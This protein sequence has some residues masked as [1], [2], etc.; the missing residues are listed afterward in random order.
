MVGMT[1]AEVDAD[2]RAPCKRGCCWTPFG[3]STARDDI[4]H[5]SKGRC[6]C[7]DRPEGNYK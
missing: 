2:Y 5:W 1:L 4:P 6:T 3:H 7:H